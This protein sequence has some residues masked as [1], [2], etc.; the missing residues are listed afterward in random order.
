MNIVGKLISNYKPDS[1]KLFNF[2]I[3]TFNGGYK[4]EVIINCLLGQSK[5]NHHITVVSDGPEEETIKQLEKYYNLQ[6]FSYF[7][8]DHRFND[9]GHTPRNFGLY[10]SECQFT[11]M[12]GFDN[13]Y[14]PVFVESFEKKYLE[15][16]NVG[17]IYCDFVLN[18][19]REGVWYNKYLDAKVQNSCIDIGC[20]AARTDII[21]E[22]GLRNDVFAA[23]WYLIEGMLPKFEQ[24]NLQIEKVNQTLYVHN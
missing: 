23:D 16:N 9:W 15:N 6:N 18:H 19:P 4:L 13:Y 1:N 8:L 20:F 24:R 14:M 5:Q 7:I 17:F 11:I 21:K 12:T 22:V 10:Q 3:P 2:V